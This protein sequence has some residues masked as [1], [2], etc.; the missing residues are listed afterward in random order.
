M[1]GLIFGEPVL[2]FKTYYVIILAGAF[3]FFLSVHGRSLGLIEAV[4]GSL[5]KNFLMLSSLIRDIK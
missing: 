5:I 3:Y 2:H 1:Q 4:F